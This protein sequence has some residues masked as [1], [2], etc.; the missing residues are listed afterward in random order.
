MGGGFTS[1]VLA[2]PGGR[3]SG[4]HPV[5]CWVSA[6]SIWQKAVGAW[7]NDSAG[8]PC[9]RPQPSA[10]RWSAIPTRTAHPSVLAARGPRPGPVG[11]RHE[12]NGD[13][14]VEPLFAAPGLILVAAVAIFEGYHWLHLVPD[15]RSV[16]HPSPSPSPWYRR[17]SRSPAASTRR[18]PARAAHRRRGDPVP[19][20]SWCLVGRRRPA[21]GRVLGV[22][23][24]F[25]AATLSVLVV[26]SERRRQPPAP[27]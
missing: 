7:M 9:C 1:R 4:G 25:L 2:V 12:P 16:P 11:A 22:T 23:S 18:P 13:E 24:L 27:D 10:P 19:R 21:V 15:G 3:G 6:P 26:A 17:P 20:G 8:G 14:P 5:V